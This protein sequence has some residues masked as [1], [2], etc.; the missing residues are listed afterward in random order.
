MKK[1]WEWLK[2]VWAWLRTDGQLHLLACLSILLI[3]NEFVPL[4]WAN[5]IA[6]LFAIGKEIYDLE[7]KKGDAEWHDLICDGIGIII[8]DLAVCLSSLLGL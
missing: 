7:T 8:G 4:K 3:A 5:V 1:I 2:G 6:A